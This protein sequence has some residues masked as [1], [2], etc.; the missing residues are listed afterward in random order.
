MEELCEVSNILIDLTKPKGWEPQDIDAF[1]TSSY[2]TW[3]L[4]HYIKRYKEWVQRNRKGIIEF[5]IT[6]NKDAKDA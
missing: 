3:R 1:G 6:S 4:D 2:T 5:V